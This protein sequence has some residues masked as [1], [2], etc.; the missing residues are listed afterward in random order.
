MSDRAHEDDQLII[1]QYERTIAE[2]KQ[3]VYLWQARCEEV[4]RSYNEREERMAEART[5]L[6]M[7]TFNKPGECPFCL[8]DGSTHAQ[9]CLTM[10]ARA[11]LEKYPAGEATEPLADEEEDW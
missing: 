1:E 6:K 8:N 11:W 5:L 3:E 7:L 4:Q 9:M 10:R 2:L